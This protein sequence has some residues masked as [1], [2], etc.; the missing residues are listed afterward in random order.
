MFAS[1]G[2]GDATLFFAPE[3]RSMM[4]S[5]PELTPAQRPAGQKAFGSESLLAAIL[6]YWLAPAFDGARFRGR[7][8]NSPAPKDS[9]QRYRP[10]AVQSHLLDSRVLTSHRPAVDR[11]PSPHLRGCLR[12]VLGPWSRTPRSERDRPGRA[13]GCGNSPLDLRAC[14]ARLPPVA[15]PR[16]HSPRGHTPGRQT[17]CVV[18]PFGVY[19]QKAKCPPQPKRRRRWL[20]LFV[21]CLPLIGS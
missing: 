1:C 7:N 5:W 16:L 3:P 12:N 15:G 4:L 19:E 2:P 17:W 21:P 9:P 11:L 8:G 20:G 6:P 14:R 13:A 18:S 10:H